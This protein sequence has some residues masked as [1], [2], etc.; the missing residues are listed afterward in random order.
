MIEVLPDV[1]ECGLILVF[2][3]TAAS[4]VSAREGAYYANP[5]NAF[6]PTLHLTGLTPRRF[7]PTEFRALLRLSI[8]LTDVAKYSAG[9]DHTLTEADFGADCLSDKI[10]RFQPQILAFTSKTACRA[11]TCKSAA[12]AVTYG[13]QDQVLGRTRV[14][15]APSPSGAAR[16][17]WDLAP[18]QALA[19]EYFR[20]IDTR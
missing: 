13:W 2:C 10:R 4:V 14:Y 19:D 8:G 6:W 16:R 1:L 11:W 15:V 9:A 5:T 18:W 17:Y 3:G 20:L 12:A 7:A